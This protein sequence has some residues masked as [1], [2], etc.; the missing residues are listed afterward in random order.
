MTIAALGHIWPIAS[1]PSGW[2][3]APPPANASAWKGRFDE[4]DDRPF[5]RSVIDTLLDAVH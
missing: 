4:T 2:R 1:A 5:T 3:P